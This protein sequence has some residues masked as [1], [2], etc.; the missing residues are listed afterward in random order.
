M[1]HFAELDEDKIVTRVV[2][3]GNDD[4]LDGD[5]EESEAVGVAYLEA[6][7]PGSGPWV[8]TSYNKN[9]RREYAG[10]G[11]AYDPTLDVFYPTSPPLD[12]T[13][14][15]FNDVTKTWEPPTPRLGVAWWWDDE[16][17]AW[18]RDVAPWDGSVWDD[19][20][21]WDIGDPDWSSYPGPVD[22][23]D[24]PSGAPFYRWN[25]DT[26]IWVAVE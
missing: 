10:R 17:G 6:L 18:W 23:D 22:E 9:I 11:M 16:A 15:V 7:L 4:C 1:A 12:C 25:G 2:V 14:Y 19:D 3:V 20:T 26:S 8:Q 21:G 5:G 13:K 24:S